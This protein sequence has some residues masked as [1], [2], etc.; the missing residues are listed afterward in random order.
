MPS[1]SLRARPAE[2][3]LLI[4]DMQND[5]ISGS[6]AV[7]RAAALLDGINRLSE[8]FP[9]SVQVAT[10]DW[11]PQ[12]HCSFAAHGGAWPEHC[13][14]DTEGAA[15]HPRLRLARVD[16]ILRKGT[17]EPVDSYSAFADAAG[18]STGLAGLLR[19]K[20]VR[21][22]AV[23]GVALDFCVCETALGARAAGFDT[24]VL[25]DLVAPVTEKKGRERVEEM[26]RAG[27]QMVPSHSLFLRSS[28]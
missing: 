10:Q 12:R 2:T 16:H 17:T 5:F 25:T 3:A 20:G 6:L 23:C 4:V 14:R 26:R 8:G 7:P 19:E 18:R 27:V 24:Y 21:A 9:F 11:H 15:L 1:Q 13:V 22:V 28:L